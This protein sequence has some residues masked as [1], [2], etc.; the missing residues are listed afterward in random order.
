MEATVMTEGEEGLIEVGRLL[1]RCGWGKEGSTMPGYDEM[2]RYGARKAA[3]AIRLVHGLHSRPA[4]EQCIA[5][6]Y[7][8]AARSVLLRSHFVL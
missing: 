2:R 1:L 7:Q 5:S 6:T 3:A 8:L 4:P